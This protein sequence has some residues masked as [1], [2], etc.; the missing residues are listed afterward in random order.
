MSLQLWAT[1]SV[2]NAAYHFNNTFFNITGIPG[3]TFG[4]WDPPFVE[5]FDHFNPLPTIWLGWAQGTADLVGST[6]APNGAND[7]YLVLGINQ[8]PQ[9]PVPPGV[10]E[11]SSMFLMGPALAGLVALL[12]MKFRTA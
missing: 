9:V 11:P 4:L 2:T 8:Q 6:A 12:G 5:N 7:I 10:P 3:G 1:D